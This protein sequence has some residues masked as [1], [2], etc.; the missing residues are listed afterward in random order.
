LVVLEANHL[1]SIGLGQMDPGSNSHR[2]HPVVPGQL[3]VGEWEIVPDV[4]RFS[5]LR[6]HRRSGHR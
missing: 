2:S 3:S 1:D 4:D 6:A 5:V